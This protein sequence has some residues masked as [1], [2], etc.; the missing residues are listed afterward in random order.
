MRRLG[1]ICSALALLA[2]IY[3][4]S[5]YALVIREVEGLYRCT[6]RYRVGGELAETVFAYCHRCDRIIRPIYWGDAANRK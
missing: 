4:A 2:V 1:L 5:Y 6:T 3:V